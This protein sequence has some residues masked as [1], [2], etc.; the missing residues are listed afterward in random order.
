MKI[1]KTKLM[2]FRTPIDF[3]YAVMNF[4]DKYYDELY[5]FRDRWEDERGYEEFDDY[6]KA[7]TDLAKE[8]SLRPFE[9]TEEIKI[10]F[11]YQKKYS[12]IVKIPKE[13]KLTTKCQ[14]LK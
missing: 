5:Y 13:G 14:I 10:I 9:I 3:Y 8:F 12:V 2:Q 4:V 6:K 11:L 1:N 7:I